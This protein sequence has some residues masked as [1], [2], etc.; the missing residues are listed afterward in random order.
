MGE[1]SHL[2]LAVALGFGGVGYALRLSWAA[3]ARRRALKLRDKRRRERLKPWSV[4]EP[5]RGYVGRAQTA[6]DRMDRLCSAAGTGPLSDQ[7]AAA[8]FRMTEATEQ[9]WALSKSGAEVFAQA[10]KVGEIGR[11]LAQVQAGLRPG[12]RS[13]GGSTR[14]WL[15]GREAALAAELRELRRT[16]G[17]AAKL[18]GDASAIVTQMESLVTQAAELISNGSPS[19]L[20]DLALHLRALGSA[21]QDAM[22]AGAAPAAGGSE[23]PAG[24]PGAGPG[25]PV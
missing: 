13:T 24:P 7:L 11:E 25:Y 18:A 12:A 15:E 21:M 16:Q 17:V 2:G 9:V 20:A 1:V 5:W 14:E 23:P 8:R 10:A 22:E 4:P 19:E 3:L 6:Q